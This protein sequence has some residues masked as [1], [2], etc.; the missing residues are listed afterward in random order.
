[1][2]AQCKLSRIRRCGAAAAARF[3]NPAMAS[4]RRKRACVASAE[5]GTVGRSG[6]R[7]ASS[8]TISARSPPPPPTSVRRLGVVM[9]LG[10]GA[11]HLHPGPVRRCPGLFVAAAPQHARI[12]LLRVA[13]EH[14]RGA[15]LAD[16]GFAG[17]HHDLP[18]AAERLLQGRAERRELAFAADEHFASPRRGAR[19]PH[20]LPGGLAKRRTASVAERRF[21]AVLPCAPRTSSHSDDDA[22]AYDHPGRSCGFIDR[23]KRHGRHARAT[24]RC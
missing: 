20:G 21:G 13:R 11:D 2:S 1:M 5:R 10:A 22:G 4:N 14:L 6:T 17:E 12:T 19:G 8:G 15:R 9:R 18:F 16:A 23:V 7:R 24:P 3:Q